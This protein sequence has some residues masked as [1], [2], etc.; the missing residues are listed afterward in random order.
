MVSAF[1][2]TF[3][4]SYGPNCGLQVDTGTFDTTYNCFGFDIWQLSSY[5]LY[6]TGEDDCPEGTSLQ[7]TF[8]ET[9]GNGIV[10]GTGELATLTVGDSQ[11]CVEGLNFA[12]AVAEVTCA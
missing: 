8:Y 6:Y 11:D 10:C 12:P 4:G 3:E 2:V 7:I 1:N 9:E 5:K